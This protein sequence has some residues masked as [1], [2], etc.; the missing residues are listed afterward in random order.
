MNKTIGAQL[1]H[2]RECFDPPLSQTH[3]AHFLGLDVSHYNQIEVDEKSF[4]FNSLVQVCEKLEGVG[5]SLDFGNNVTSADIAFFSL[6]DFGAWLK[7][8]R[9][10]MG[11]KSYEFADFINTPPT[12]LSR[13]EAGNRNPGPESLLQILGIIKN[14]AKMQ[15]REQNI[16]DIMSVGGKMLLNYGKPEGEYLTP[17]EQATKRRWEV[18]QTN[19]MPEKEKE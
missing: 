8:T 17:E 2:I 6:N 4:S 12:A 16:Q 14:Y 9:K 3:M 15:V 1:K 18:V 19:W 7:Q 10:E 11:I 5:T 13:M